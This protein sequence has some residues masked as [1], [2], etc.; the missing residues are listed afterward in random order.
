MTQ[1]E[2]KQF[3]HL[4]FHRGILHPNLRVRHDRDFLRANFR[5]G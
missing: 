2:E 5:F 3:S 1:L 4:A